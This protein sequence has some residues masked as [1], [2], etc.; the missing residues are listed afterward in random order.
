MDRMSRMVWWLDRNL[1]GTDGSILLA[2]LASP[3]EGAGLAPE[4]FW[5][6]PS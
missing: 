4:Q 5:Y 1:I 6:R 3:A 2:K